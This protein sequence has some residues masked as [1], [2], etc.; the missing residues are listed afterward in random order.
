MGLRAGLL[1]ILGTFGMVQ[2][3]CDTDT[4]AAIA[5]MTVLPFLAPQITPRG[6]VRSGRC[7][8]QK[9]SYTSILQSL[10]G[11]TGWEKAITFFTFVLASCFSGAPQSEV[12]T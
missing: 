6:P 3:A 2:L 1:H 4:I 7:F 8:G 12:S 5:V 11:N 9:Q 10:F